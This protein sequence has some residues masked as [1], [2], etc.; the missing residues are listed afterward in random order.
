MCMN[1]LDSVQTLKVEGRIKYLFVAAFALA[2]TYKSLYSTHN[3]ILPLS[4][5][6]VLNKNLKHWTFKIELS[7]TH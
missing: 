5:Q 3:G 6:S 1:S 7:R 2:K 4:K